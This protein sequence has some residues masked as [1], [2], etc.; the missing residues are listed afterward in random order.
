[1]LNFNDE[2]T[3]RIWNICRI[4]RVHD[5]NRDGFVDADAIG[6][7]LRDL[8]KLN[9]YILR[10]GSINDPDRAV[11]S[12]TVEEA[13]GLLD[14]DGSG[15]VDMT[16]YLTWL[17]QPRDSSVR[18]LSFFRSFLWLFVVVAWLLRGILCSKLLVLM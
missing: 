2:A 4:F 12:F 13:T 3:R 9:V 6:T 10:D 5:N 18:T 7:I 1:M 11:S 16:E 14:I 8:S 17:Q 15:T